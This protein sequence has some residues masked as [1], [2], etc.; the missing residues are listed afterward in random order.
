MTKTISVIGLG[1][2]GLPTAALLAA[3]GYR[4]HGMDVSK[5]VVETIN[6]GEIHIVEDGLRAYV[7]EAVSTGC[8]T[9]HLIPQPA[10][11]HMICVPTPLKTDASRDTPWPDISYVEQAAQSISGLV[12]VGD[13]VILESTSPV[14]TTQKVA[15]ILSQAGVDLESVHIAYCPE[16]VL[17]GKIMIELLENDRI[18]GGV[19]PAATAIV[20]AFY[21]EFVQGQV[22]ETDAQTAE[23]SKLAE[24]SFRDVN[25]A[26]ANE[27]SMIC[28][29][30]GVDPWKLIAMANHHPRVN[31]LNPGAGVGGHCIAVDPWF[32]V[33]R[34]PEQAQLIKTARQVNDAKPRWVEAKIKEAVTE[35]EKTVNRMPKL[36]CYGL[37]FKPDI[38]DL[39]ESPAMEIVQNLL[40][41]F[42]NLSVVEPNVSAITGI[43]LTDLKD[44]QKEADIHV[45]LVGH[46]EFARSEDF[47]GKI[48][49]FVGKFSQDHS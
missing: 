22:L 18:I 26:F 15:N 43:P 4:V 14:G 47:D 7:N 23:L 30:E 28:E 35:F 37:A 40:K 45:V 46:K 44:A 11:V 42:P 13:M 3:K 36:A 29:A 34:A 1:Y 41:G 10:D 25:I 20:S 24:N 8:L 5:S 33:A 38:D 2:I 12:K 16:R 6:R 39:R 21:Q 19:T 31:I 49:D 9:A 32:I 17:P 48:L 27:L